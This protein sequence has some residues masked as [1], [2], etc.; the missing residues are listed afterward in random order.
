MA[1]NPSATGHETFDA[2]FL[3]CVEDIGK[4]LQR[5]SR[6]YDMTVVVGALAEHVGSALHALVRKKVCDIGQAHKAIEHI[7]NS[8]FLHRTAAPTIQAPPSGTPGSGTPTA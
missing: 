2:S 4:M 6:R 1:G 3:K 5:L 8:A 7:E